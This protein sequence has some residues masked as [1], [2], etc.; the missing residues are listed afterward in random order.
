MTVKE[1]GSPI[2]KT[3]PEAVEL[4]T[5]VANEHSVDDCYGRG[6]K[7]GLSYAVD[8]LGNLARGSGLKDTAELKAN[9]VYA[10]CVLYCACEGR[11]V[12]V[13]IEKRLVK[14]ECI[15]CGSIHWYNATGDDISVPSR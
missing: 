4:L 13:G 2:P 10:S 9:L 15:K 5:E 6:I 3:L 14:H 8:I 12:F 11:L 1:L 7:F